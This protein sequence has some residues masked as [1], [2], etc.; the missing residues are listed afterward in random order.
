MNVN[1]DTERRVLGV[2][3]ERRSPRRTLNLDSEQSTY[4]YTY[5]SGPLNAHA[6]ANVAR[7]AYERI[8]SCL[9]ADTEVLILVAA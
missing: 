6:N 8:V 4:T 9:H 2:E 7:H 5:A 1:G 3:L